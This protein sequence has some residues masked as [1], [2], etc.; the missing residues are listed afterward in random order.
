[1]NHEQFT[2][3]PLADSSFG[4]IVDFENPDL[5][6]TVTAL[7]ADPDA[8][9]DALIVSQGL[10]VLPKVEAITNDPHLLLRLSRL[11]GP[12][13]E[14]YRHTL[15]TGNLVHREVPQIL[16]LA[17]Q[18]PSNRQPPPRPDPP[19]S[20]DGKLPVQFPHRRGWH[21]DQS[22]RR[23]PPDV[24]LFYAVIP[25]PK[26]TGQTL[27]ANGTAAYEAL[28]AELKTRVQGLQG[29]HALPWTGR[30]E[31]AVNRGEPLVDLLP[32]QAP[33]RQPVIRIHPVTGKPALYL[34]E[35]AQMDW[36][37]G[38]IAGMEP[39]SHGDGG[40]LLY[41]LMNHFTERR[42]TYAHDWDQGDLVVHD[43]RNVIHSATWFDAEHEVRHMWRTTVMGNPGQEYDGEQ[44]S[45]IPP[46]GVESTQGLADQTNQ[47]RR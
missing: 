6:E 14:D 26:G 38:P 21:T 18:P 9:L 44:P 17:N 34:C 22:F 40:R 8:L 45:W 33:Q 23:P 25:C 1:M 46:P 24:S 20:P 3:R 36:V 41:Q 16:V 12:Q 31:T 30:S 37:D 32:H 11:F 35:D 47:E 2:L 39:G 13:V 43:N 4:A 5:T 27:Y 42:F 29:V 15:S 7:E 19:L 10:L 28:P